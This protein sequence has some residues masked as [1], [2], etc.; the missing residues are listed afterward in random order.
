MMDLISAQERS[1]AV[2][3]RFMQ[4]R[5]INWKPEVMV[6]DMAEEFGELARSILV[7]RGFKIKKCK[8][9]EDLA[10]CL[11]DIL[12][13]IFMI[14]NHYG[15]DMETEYGK[16]LQHLLKRIESGEFSDE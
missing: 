8:Q 10:D 1:K 9:V 16:V 15:I 7:D 11:C 2:N 14:A 12:F 3:K 13:D 6:A 5:K 4:T